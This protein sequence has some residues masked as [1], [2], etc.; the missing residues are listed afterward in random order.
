MQVAFQAGK[1]A[2]GCRAT[3]VSVMAAVAPKKIL[4]LGAR[5]GSMFG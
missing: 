4:M 3:A 2:R 1:P 5:Q